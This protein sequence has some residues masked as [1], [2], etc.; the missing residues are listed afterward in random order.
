MSIKEEADKLRR[1]V[2]ESTISYFIA[3]LSVVAG[4]AWN[5]AIASA[6]AL[7]FPGDASSIIAKFTYAVLITI[8]VVLLTVG[9]KRLMKKDETS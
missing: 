7:L 5:D 9:I 8:L 6:I 1:A 4:L 2:L 3:A